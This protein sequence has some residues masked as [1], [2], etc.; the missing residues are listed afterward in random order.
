MPNLSD[1]DPAVKYGA[2]LDVNVDLA[3]IRDANNN[4]ILELDTVASAVGFVGIANAATGNN[5]ALY[6][7][8]E[9]DS[10]L[11]IFNDQ[12]EEIVVFD[13]NA[14]AVNQIEVNNAAASSNPS[15][16]ATG[17]DTNI[18][19]ALTPK[20]TGLA[21]VGDSSS[22]TVASGSALINAQRGIIATTTL[23]AATASSQ[24]FDLVNNKIAVE[25][26]ILVSLGKWNGTTGIPVLGEVECNVAGSCTIRVVNADN[27]PAGAAL[28]GTAS[29]FF[30]VLS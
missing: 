14:S 21:L 6:A 3:D 28:N 18:S 17:D 1:Y 30:L 4:E 20:G 25:S 19:L 2:N 22:G 5:P 12:G 16:E 9:A 24:T 23:S 11:T 7:T 13:A 15:V 29:I 26:L 10:G 27:R 8:G